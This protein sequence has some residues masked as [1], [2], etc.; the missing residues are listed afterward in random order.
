MKSTF[1]SIIYHSSGSIFCSRGTVSIPYGM[2]CKQD[3]PNMMDTC[4][5]PSFYCLHRWHSSG[6]FVDTTV[7]IKIGSTICFNIGIQKAHKSDVGSKYKIIIFAI[8]FGPATIYYISVQ[9]PVIRAEKLFRLLGCL[10]LF[11]INCLIS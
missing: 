8:P 10:V 5:F 11:A 4:Q 3:C 6:D 9:I 2:V 1:R 7:F